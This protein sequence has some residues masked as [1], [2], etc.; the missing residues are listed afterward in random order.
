M[1]AAR[2][3]AEPADEVVVPVVAE[4]PSC[5][6]VCTAGETDI[7]VS[8]ALACVKVLKGVPM[9]WVVDSGSGNHL[10][11]QAELPHP[12]R[13]AVCR[14]DTGVRL[15]TANGIISADEVVQVHLPGL[16]SNAEILVLDSCPRVLSL[17]RLVEDMNCHFSWVPGRAWITDSEGGEHDCVV[18][19]YVPSLSIAV[20]A[21]ATEAF[22]AAPGVPA[23]IA[24]GSTGAAMSV[25]SDVETFTATLTALDPRGRAGD[26][27]ARRRRGCRSWS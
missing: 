11:G 3:R 2:C 22:S 13:P 14:R 10:S 1:S 17:G 5:A 20:K 21:S 24:D 8:K 23:L 15:A 18:H 12:L 7:D 27:A 19:N 6:G 26:C 16:G 25:H 9:K 4:A